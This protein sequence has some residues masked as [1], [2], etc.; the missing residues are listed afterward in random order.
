MTVYY[1]VLVEEQYVE[2]CQVLTDKSNTETLVK[3]LSDRNWKNN[4]IRAAEAETILDLVI[5]I[6]DY[7]KRMNRGRIV[8]YN[9]NLKLI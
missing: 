6:R 3:L 1:N 5:A 8:M 9:D 2:A 4:R 7:T